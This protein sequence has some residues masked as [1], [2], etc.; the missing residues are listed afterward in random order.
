MAKQDGRFSRQLGQ[1]ACGYKGE[2]TQGSHKGSHTVIVINTRVMKS[3]DLTQPLPTQPQLPLSIS[4]CPHPPPPFSPHSPAHSTMSDP[5]YAGY[6]AVGG[7]KVRF[8]SELSVLACPPCVPSPP[9]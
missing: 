7:P 8:F 2:A 3:D 9:Y 5:I 4:F 6:M 1:D